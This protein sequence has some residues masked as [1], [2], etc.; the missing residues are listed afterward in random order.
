MLI[1]TEAPADILVIDRLLKSVFET[2]AEANLVMSLRENSHLTLSLVACSDDGEV[3]GHLMF[4]PLTLAGEDHNW[5][6]LAPLAVKAEYRNQ[7]IA[8]SLVED[9]FSTLVDFGYPACVVL[10]DPAYY[11]RFGFK[12]ASEF[13]LSCAWDVPE[14]AFQ[15]IELVEGALAGH[16]GEIAYSP[17]FNDL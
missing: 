16:S 5:Q 2:D 12:A 10:G 7:G 6:G 17:E 1:R 9:A 4:S 3:V 15:V 11:G 14:G 13:G 8:K